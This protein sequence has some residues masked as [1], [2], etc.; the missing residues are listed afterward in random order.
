MLDPDEII[1]WLLGPARALPSPAPLLQ[2]LAERLVRAGYPLWRL[3]FHLP[4]FQPQVSAAAYE[5]RPALDAVR[6][7]RFERAL[8]ETPTYHHSPM[9]E[10]HRTGQMVRRRLVGPQ[11]D[12]AFPVLQELR[13]QGATDYTLLPMRFGTDRWTTGFGLASDAPEGF[14]DEQIACVEKLLPALGAVCEI[15]VDRQKMGQ[16]LETYVG[17]EASRRILDGEMV[18][19]GARSLEAVILFCDMRGFTARAEATPRDALLQLMNEYFTIVVGAVHGAGGEVLKFMGDGILAIFRLGEGEAAEEACA[20]GLI[21]ALDAFAGLDAM[22]DRRRAEGLDA[23]DAGIALHVGEV[24]F[25]N[26]GAPDRLD[27][28]VVGPEV[29]RAARIEQMTKLVGRRILTSSRFA[30]LSPVRL[31]SAGTRR[32]R[33]VAQ[34]QE[35]FTPAPELRGETIPDAA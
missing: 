13:D 10:M 1:G 6:E 21:G 16:L 9:G 11:A 28:T 32:L 15:M 33:G 5:W 17:R 34:P 18:R 4:Q 12:L 2:A 14:S 24:I 27:F 25:G 30:E 26:I 3:S 20:R 7:I 31:V 22:N 8:S 19:G 29:N 23:I 35:L